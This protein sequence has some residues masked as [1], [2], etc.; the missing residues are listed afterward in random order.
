MEISICTLCHVAGRSLP[1]LLYGDII[2]C[3]DKCTNRNGWPVLGTCYSPKYACNYT[4]VAT[5]SHIEHT[6][7]VCGKGGS[8]G[9]KGSLATYVSKIW[10]SCTLGRINTWLE[11]WYMP[12]MTD[13]TYKLT[14]TILWLECVLTHTEP[15]QLAL[16]GNVAAYRP[17]ASAQHMYWDVSGAMWTSFYCV[18]IQIQWSRL[19][20]RLELAR[21]L[22]SL[23]THFH[24]RTWQPNL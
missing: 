7:C 15:R 22:F 11:Y 1:P 12:L 8:W 2:G 17:W 18:C 6:V 13:G 19:C 16:Q 3:S 24:Y 5:L 10:P 21:R 4:S 23:V 20:N 9:R 14:T